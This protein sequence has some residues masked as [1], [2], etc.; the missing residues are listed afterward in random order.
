MADATE[1]DPSVLPLYQSRIR[2]RVRLYYFFKHFQLRARTRKGCK[3]NRQNA[4]F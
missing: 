1:A 4:L 2:K 3:T